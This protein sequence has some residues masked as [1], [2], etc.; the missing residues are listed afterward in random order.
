MKKPNR[1]L[2]FLGILL[3]IGMAILAFSIPFTKTKFWAVILTFID[4]LLAVSG[5]ACMI[6][7][8]RGKGGD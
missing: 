6:L 4:V 1:F 5:I 7:S 3:I 2:M 8:Y